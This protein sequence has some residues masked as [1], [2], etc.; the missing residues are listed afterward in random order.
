MAVPGQA[1]KGAKFPQWSYNTVTH[2]VA[3]VPNSTAK[4][5]ADLVSFPDKIIFFATEA[6]ADAYEKSQGGGVDITGS[7]IQGA[8]NA[9]ASAQSAAQSGAS[10]VLSW[11]NQPDLWTRLGEILVGVILLYTGF[12][13]VT[14]ATPV[15]DVANRTASTGKKIYSTARKVAK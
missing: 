9:T 14:Q 15:G 12:K 13:A 3:E 8:V 6:A 1:G 2:E 10:S 7:P 11:L 5:M 4:A